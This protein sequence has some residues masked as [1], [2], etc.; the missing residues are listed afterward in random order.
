MSMTG[1]LCCCGLVF[2]GVIIGGLSDGG[3]QIAGGMITGLGVAG[4]VIWAY[5]HLR[6]RRPRRGS[7]L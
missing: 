2:L 5:P 4:I 1:L 7:W 6:T 3:W